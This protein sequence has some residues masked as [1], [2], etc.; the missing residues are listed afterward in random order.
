VLQNVVFQAM[1]LKANT[2][3]GNY[4]DNTTV[5]LGKYIGADIFIE[6]M[7]TLKY[8]PEKQSSNG[9]TLEPEIGLEMRNPLFDI[10]LNMLLVR[11]ETFFSDIT[12]SLIWRRSF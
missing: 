8:D 4:F 3:V 11:P 7:L 5:F 9:L 6:S 1:G 12:L 10:R 2:G